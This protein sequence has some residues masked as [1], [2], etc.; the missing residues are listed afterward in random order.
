MDVHKAPSPVPTVAGPV[1]PDTSYYDEILQRQAAEISEVKK[2]L[3]TT[4]ADYQ[5]VW[6]Y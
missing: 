4:E 3:V 5:V 2:K 1:R 6:S